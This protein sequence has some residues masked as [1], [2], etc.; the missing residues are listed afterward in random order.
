LGTENSGRGKFEVTVTLGHAIAV[1]AV[2]AL[3]LLG[4][5]VL[6]VRTT[7]PIFPVYCAH[8]WAYRRE[9]TTI[10]FSEQEGQ[11]GICQTCVHSYWQ[12]EEEE[13]GVSSVSL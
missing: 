2:S 1:I 10:T 12:F 7:K 5:A 9:K 3:I 8:C 13:F 4:I 11:W 6:A